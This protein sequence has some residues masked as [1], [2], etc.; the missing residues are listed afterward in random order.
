MSSY[1]SYVPPTALIIHGF[2]RFMKKHKKKLNDKNMNTIL[3]L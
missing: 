3:H 1:L 2:C